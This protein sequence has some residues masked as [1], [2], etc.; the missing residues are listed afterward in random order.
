MLIYRL[1]AD[2]VL[3]LHFGFVLFVILGQAVVV[4][5]LGLRWGWVRNFWFRTVHLGAIVFIVAQTW[6]N[7]VCPLTDLENYFRAYAGEATYPGGCI[8]YWIERILFYDMESWVFKLSYT[9]FGTV[10]LLSWILGPPRWRR[11]VDH[12]GT[13][14]HEGREA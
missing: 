2:A 10:T 12:E 5:G 9:L 1:L 4:I 13:K 3:I 6:L 14:K 7:W 11:K 8:S